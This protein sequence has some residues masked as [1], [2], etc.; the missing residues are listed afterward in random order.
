MGLKHV[1]YLI[2]LAS[3]MDSCYLV[4]YLNNICV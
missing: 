2:N 4:S 1:N 3:D